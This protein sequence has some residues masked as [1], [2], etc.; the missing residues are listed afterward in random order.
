MSVT[1]QLQ[2]YDTVQAFRLRRTPQAGRGLAFSAPD[3][4]LRVVDG[5]RA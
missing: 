3:Q 2:F 5:V 4:L 1:I